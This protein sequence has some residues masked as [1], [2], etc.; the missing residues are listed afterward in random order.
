M[1]KPSVFIGSSSEGLEFARAVRSLLNK[2]AEITIWNEGFFGLGNTFIETL[3]NALPR[4]DFAILTL[5][6]DDLVSSRESE[7]FGPRDNVIFELG[8]FMG[9]LGR[10][11]TFILNQ[12]AAALKIPTDLSGITTATYDWPRSDKSY[13]SAVGAACDTIR[14]IIRDLGFA[15]KKVAR[16]LSDIRARQETT[17]SRIESAENRIDRIFAHSM[18]DTM[19]ENLR[20]LSTG[21]FGHFRNSGP[22]RRELRYLRGIG[23]IKV[24]GYIGHL[25]NRGDNL[26]DFITVSDIG[27]DFVKLRE[28]LEGPMTKEA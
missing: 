12:A 7:T 26:S 24:R 3:V 8:L 4:F 16:Q 1:T 15:E 22:L 11:R 19:F 18:S 2:D 28:D 21:R 20:K 17:E 25:P 6:P 13:K 9:H 5:T 23:Y 27:K 10:S 14:D